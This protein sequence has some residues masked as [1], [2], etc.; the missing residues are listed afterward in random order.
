MGF[1]VTPRFV[2]TVVYKF[3]T[4]GRRSLTLD[5]FIQ[6]CVMIKSL[7]DAFKQRDTSM[8]GTITL[9]YEDFMTMAVLYKP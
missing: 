2:Q 1:N 7:T 9:G 6:S 4:Y 3:D 5:N 8:T